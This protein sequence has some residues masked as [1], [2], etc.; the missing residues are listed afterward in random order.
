MRT[1]T[2]CFDGSKEGPPI[3]S[4]EETVKSIEL[5]PMLDILDKLSG[6]ATSDKE[7]AQAQVEA[8]QILRENGS[9]L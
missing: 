4:T 2:L 9:K 7:L 5:E 3:T 1:W 8:I 6:G